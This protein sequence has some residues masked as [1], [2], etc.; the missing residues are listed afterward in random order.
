MPNLKTSVG[1]LIKMNDIY[2]KIFDYYFEKLNDDFFLY[3]KRDFA[4]FVLLKTIKF[5]RSPSFYN[6]LLVCLFKCRLLQSQPECLLLLQIVAKCLMIVF[7]ERYV[8]FF[9]ANGGLIGM[10]KY[11]DEIKKEDLRSFVSR[12][13]NSEIPTFE[14]V[15]KIV[16]EFDEYDFMDFD[17]GDS[18]LQYVYDYYYPF[19]EI[20]IIGDNLK[21]PES[22]VTLNI[23]DENKTIV[24]LMYKLVITS[25]Q[26]L[27]RALMKCSFCGEKCFKYLLSQ[28]LYR[29]HTK[30]KE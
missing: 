29:L 12:H 9:M 14:D 30:R 8:D 15:F 22:P 2:G 20:L 6:F 10:R 27:N 4:V 17:I 26:E 24:C 18:E 3:S 28:V 19:D 21:L 16:R 5:C 23:D 7:T 25:E 1:N 11:F 13:A